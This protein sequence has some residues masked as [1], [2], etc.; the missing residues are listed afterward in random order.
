[1]IK[2]YKSSDNI[3]TLTMDMDG[4]NVNIINHGNSPFHYSATIER[5]VLEIYPFTKNQ[6]EADKNLRL[7]FGLDNW[8]EMLW[9]LENEHNIKLLIEPTKADFGFMTIIEDLGWTQ[10]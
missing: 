10:N 6:N 1:M 5:T 9:K 8:D 2:Y 7:G 4:R 3:V